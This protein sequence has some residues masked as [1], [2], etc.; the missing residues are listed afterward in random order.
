[1]IIFLTRITHIHRYTLP[2]KVKDWRSLIRGIFQT[3]FRKEEKIKVRNAAAR[4]MVISFTRYLRRVDPST[5]A[6]LYDK[7]S[8]L[9]VGIDEEDRRKQLLTGLVDEFTSNID[10]HLH[11]STCSYL[12]RVLSSDHFGLARKQARATAAAILRS[13]S[14][15]GHQRSKDGMISEPYVLSLS[16]SLSL[17]ALSSL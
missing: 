2:N 4:N 11:R 14:W 17:S 10:V 12:A 15:W 9:I 1:M 16:L 7:I 13:C 3:A 5:N 6:S 8:S